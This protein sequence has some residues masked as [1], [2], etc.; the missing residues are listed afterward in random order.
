MKDL[1]DY[2]VRH[3]NTVAYQADTYDDHPTYNTVVAIKH[4]AAEV[5]GMYVMAMDHN[6]MRGNE[7]ASAAMEK[8]RF[9]VSALQERQKLARELAR[10]RKRGYARTALPKG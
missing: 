7:K 5:Q 10:G 4:S 6:D 1:Y 2:V 3:A 8:M 9:A